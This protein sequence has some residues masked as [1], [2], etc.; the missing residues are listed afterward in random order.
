MNEL[1]EKW[2]CVACRFLLGYVE[3][4]RIVRIKRKDL[5]VSCEGGVV[6]INC[7]RCGKVN[8]LEDIKDD[9]ITDIQS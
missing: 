4:K 5:Y 6:T 3:N 7:P 8:V 2:L 9:K 1:A